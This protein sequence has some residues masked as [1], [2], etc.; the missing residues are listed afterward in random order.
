VDVPVRRQ[1]AWRNATVTSA[2]P[3]S[4][5]AR[6]LWIDVPGWDDHVAGQHID[7]RLTAEDGYQATRSYSLSS[8]PGEVPQITVE[9]VDD[10]EVSPFLVDV[11][12]VG[13]TFEI[14]GPIGG[15]FVWNPTA[16]RQPLLLIGGGSGIAPLR[17]I[18]R[19]PPTTSR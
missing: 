18:W 7:V 15:Y 1:L 17:A 16:E 2:T 5:T 11:V 19:P 3:E 9:R 13:D 10:G 8:G 6:S 14:R 4:A 12:E